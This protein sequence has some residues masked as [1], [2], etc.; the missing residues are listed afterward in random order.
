MQIR[1]CLN[2]TAKDDKNLED[3]SRS[4][5][6]RKQRILKW[7]NT[8]SLTTN[9][10]WEDKKKKSEELKISISILIKVTRKLIDFIC[11]NIL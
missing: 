7:Y 2:I 1:D 4:R 6:K 3:T 8:Q 9:P 5:K 10:R 11:D